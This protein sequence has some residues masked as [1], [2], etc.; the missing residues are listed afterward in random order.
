MEGR[1][2]DH[3]TLSMRHGKGTPLGLRA[4]VE[5]GPSQGTRSGSTGP[6]WASFPSC[7]SCAFF[8]QGGRLAA[9]SLSFLRPHGART[10]ESNRLPPASAPGAQHR[11]RCQSFRLPILLS[12]PFHSRTILSLCLIQISVLTIREKIKNSCRCSFTIA[13]TGK[14]PKAANAPPEE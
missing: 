12:V 2:S 3:T 14:H 6:T 9:P 13:T 4:A 1:E 7:S 8:E 5:R 10:Q 11:H